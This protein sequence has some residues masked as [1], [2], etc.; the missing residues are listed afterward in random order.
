MSS[1][2]SLNHEQQETEVGHKEEAMRRNSEGL[3]VEQD[4]DDPPVL[5]TEVKVA[6]QASNRTHALNLSVPSHSAERHLTL[7]HISA[8]HSVPDVAPRL[9][10]A[11]HCF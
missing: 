3:E 7:V 9:G 5:R 2:G 6:E 8:A 1:E 10:M 11:C 4:A